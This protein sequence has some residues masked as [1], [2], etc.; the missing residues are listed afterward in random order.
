[1]FSVFCKCQY[2][3]HHMSDEQS[4]SGRTYLHGGAHGEGKLAQWTFQNVD[5][6]NRYKDF[7]S[8]QNVS[9]INQHINSKHR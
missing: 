3:T 2:L 5:E 6:S 7:L 4:S 1:M 9:L 8:I